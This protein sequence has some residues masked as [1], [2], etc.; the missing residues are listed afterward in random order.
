MTQHQLHPVLAYP[1]SKNTT[2]ST[3]DR[4]AQPP[5]ENRIVC[6]LQHIL[7]PFMHPYNTHAKHNPTNKIESPIR[8]STMKNYSTSLRL[9]NK[10][11]ERIIL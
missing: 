7:I 1:N 8:N 2:P 10:S 9:P 5:S 3:A 4:D 6:K 11:G